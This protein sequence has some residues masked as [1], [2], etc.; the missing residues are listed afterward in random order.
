[1]VDWPAGDQNGMD[2]RIYLG[3]DPARLG[4]GF[5]E[6]AASSIDPGPVN[7]MKNKRKNR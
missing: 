5:A 4:L 2:P 1:M 7:G 3:M 6:A